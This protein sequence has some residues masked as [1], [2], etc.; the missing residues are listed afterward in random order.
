[1][2][3]PTL[4]LCVTASREGQEGNGG[5]EAH[6]LGSIS[7]W[8]DAKPSTGLMGNSLYLHHQSFPALEQQEL[9][10]RRDDDDDD[11]LKLTQ[12]EPVGI[13]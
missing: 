13:L 9:I 8:T 4:V 12:K 5:R 6:L 11:D 10:T 2:P 3:P 7:D 1:M